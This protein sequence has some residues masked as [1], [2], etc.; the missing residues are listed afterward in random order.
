MRD[1]NFSVDLFNLKRKLDL[2]IQFGTVSV[3]SSNPP[4]KNDNQKLCLIKY[5][6]NIHVFNS[7]ID[8]V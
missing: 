1:R 6:L 4:C 3:I 8:Y 5:E 7:K 2:D